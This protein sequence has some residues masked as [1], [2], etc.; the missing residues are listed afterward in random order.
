MQVRDV[1]TTNPVCCVPTDTAQK[2]AQV[3][4]DNDIGS[5]PVVS[6]QASRNLVG[7]ITDR[8]VCCLIVADGMDPKTT[9]IETYVSAHPV[10][11]YEG[12]NLDL[13]EQAMQKHQIRRIPVVDDEGR[14]VGI[15][16]QADLAMKGEPEKVSKTV[17]EISK[18]ESEA[19]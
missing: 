18:P 17:A 14:C 4:R 1:M 11:C 5:V 15:V 9:S 16:A 10:A 6:D 3:L 7:I 13:A 8:D 12:D 19:A 2:V